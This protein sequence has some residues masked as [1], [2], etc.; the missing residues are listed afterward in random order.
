MCCCVLFAYSPYHRVRDGIHYPA[1]LIVAGTEDNNVFPAH[2]LKFA[3]ALQH[4][5]SGSA[6]ILLYEFSN[7]GHYA[8]LPTEDSE[9]FMLQA[10]GLKP[11]MPLKGQR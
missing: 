6:P 4:A 11:V 9:A 2:S 5:Q 10:M 1:M 8:E 3:A 7:K